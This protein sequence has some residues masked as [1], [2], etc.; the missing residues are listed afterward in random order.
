[1][2]IFLIARKVWKSDGWHSKD[3][4]CRGRWPNTRRMATHGVRFSSPASYWKKFLCVGDCLIF[5]KSWPLGHRDREI[6]RA[7]RW[8]HHHCTLWLRTHEGLQGQEAVH[9]GRWH[10][11]MW[12]V[13]L[14][15]LLPLVSIFRSSPSPSPLLWLTPIAPL[16]LSLM[17]SLV[18]PIHSPLY[19]FA[20]L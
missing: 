13:H 10:H 9:K 17:I 5:L 1:M 3:L 18:I 16:P 15:S 20:H 4:C 19:L 14:P 6:C 8:V 11:P 7:Y 12:A 2:S